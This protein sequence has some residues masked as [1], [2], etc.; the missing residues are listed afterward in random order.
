MASSAFSMLV[1]PR[2][3]ADLSGQPQTCFLHRR[4]FAT[5]LQAAFWKVHTALKSFKSTDGFCIF[6]PF[7]SYLVS[8]CP[9]QPH[10]IRDQNKGVP[11]WHTRA[12]E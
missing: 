4:V 3:R 5:I 6:N 1:Y 11:V 8:L 12:L 9:T 7:S 2:D 10:R